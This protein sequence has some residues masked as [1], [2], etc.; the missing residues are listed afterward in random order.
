MRIKEGNM[1]PN[2]L[3]IEVVMDLLKIHLISLTTTYSK[4]KVELT[5]HH[6]QQEV[7][8]AEKVKILRNR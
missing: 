6:I 2:L 3:Q 7:P 1:I 5:I 8:G 4:I